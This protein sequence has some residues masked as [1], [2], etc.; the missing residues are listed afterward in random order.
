MTTNAPTPM[1]AAATIPNLRMSAPVAGSRPLFT[2]ARACA[3]GA[4]LAA[5]TCGA[6]ISEAAGEGV[7]G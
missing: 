7:D 3:V 2:V 5:F 4:V 6:G 1:S